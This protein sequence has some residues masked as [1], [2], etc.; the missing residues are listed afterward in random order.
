MTC[1]TRLPDA[2]QRYTNQIV[3]EWL[4][5]L[6]AQAQAFIRE[7]ARVAELSVVESPGRP[8]Y[9]TWTRNVIYTP[10]HEPLKQYAA[11]LAEQQAAKPPGPA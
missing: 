8:P 5:P 6:L 3:T 2:G 7:G 10:L 4:A 9:V 1:P 11:E